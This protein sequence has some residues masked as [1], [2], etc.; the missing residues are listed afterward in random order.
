MEPRNFNTFFFLLRIWVE[1]LPWEHEES[2]GCWSEAQ[3]LE[4]AQH[5][6]I[7]ILL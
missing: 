2:F 7:I 4:F 1:N 5:Y 6:V 3:L